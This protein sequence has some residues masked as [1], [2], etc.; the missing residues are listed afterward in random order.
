MLYPVLLLL[1]LAAAACLALSR[2]A[3]TRWLGLIAAVAAAI[4]A[5]ALPANL[6]PA[7][8]TL[9]WAV[10]DGFAFT[11]APDLSGTDL[12]LGLTLLGGG[13]LAL[14]A[15]ALALAPTVRGF[16]GLFAWP[17]LAMGAALLS[18][19]A[20]GP[21]PLFPFTWALAALLSYSAVRASGALTRSSAFPQGLTLGLLA[22]LLLL[23]GLLAATTLRTE[24]PLPGFAAFAALAVLLACQMLVGGAPFHSVFEEA[25]AAPAALGGLFF[26]LLLP[27][28]AL[29]TLFHLTETLPD[30]PAFWPALL[31]GLGLLNLLTGT[32]GALRERSLRRLLAWQVSAQA[33]VV[34]L[35]LGME[36]PL[37]ALAAPA[38]LV[39][40]ALATLAG[41]LA[42]SA[43]ERLTGS[44]DFTLVRPGIDLRWPGLLWAL[45]AA[46]SLGLPP[47]WGFWGRRWA[48][49]AA[50]AAAPWLAATL[51]AAT[52]LAL[53]AYLGPL[54]Q[55]WG[56]G[57]RRPAPGDAPPPT[58]ALDAVL[59]LALAPL[60]MLGLVPQLLWPGWLQT[61][62][63]APPALPVSDVAQFAAIVAAVAVMLL[64][65]LVRGRRWT[66]RL[67]SDPDMT[68]V[69]LGPDALGASVA[70]LAHLGRP[71][72]LFR[73][74]WEGLLLVSRGA[75][76]AMALFEQR[77]YLA[78]VL[79]MLL[80]VLLLMAL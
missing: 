59:M 73:R 32:A 51:L 35:A 45:A 47:L 62:A 63:G 69:V 34:L 66:R 80:I 25:V 16:G 61:V 44:D 12:A 26:G 1:L 77:F 68:P 20:T 71:A 70:P 46:S 3:P 65:L 28:L 15:L 14:L 11:L 52:L 30:L 6:F 24:E 64:T 74:A 67:G 43:Q 2:L 27:L 13:A 17:L 22:S 21:T 72:G 10:I 23:G 8:P 75:Q 36:G 79:L 37:A 76:A 19:G 41:A 39:N 60:L 7:A 40:L 49:E 31:I 42:V 38:L 78:G 50:F 33:G 55:F 53:L 5:L 18:F 48:L 56:A 57:T 54:A 58:W 4:A 29:R 9:T